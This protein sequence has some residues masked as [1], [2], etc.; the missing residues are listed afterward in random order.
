[1]APKVEIVYKPHYDTKW[2]IYVDG[3]VFRNYY[4][5]WFAE[6]A[7]RKILRNP[8]DYKNF[9]YEVKE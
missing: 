3:V 6:R 7:A 5:K 2:W 8:Q 4:T 9:R 1:M